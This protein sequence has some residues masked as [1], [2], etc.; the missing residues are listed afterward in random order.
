MLSI[1]QIVV[2]RM[3]LYKKQHRPL[4]HR[5]E[6]GRSC[7]AISQEKVMLHNVQERISNKLITHNYRY[8]LQSLTEILLWQFL[9]AC[10]V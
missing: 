1:Y 8:R 6:N 3:G 5:T 9:V 2:Y 4:T 10:K 7:I